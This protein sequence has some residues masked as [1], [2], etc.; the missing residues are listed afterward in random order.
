MKI[1]VLI[2]ILIVFYQFSKAQTNSSITGAMPGAVDT[3]SVL[4]SQEVSDDNK[5]LVDK[6]VDPEKYIVGPGDEFKVTIMQYEPKEI[7]VTVTLEN[8]TPGWQT[9]LPATVVL[10]RARAN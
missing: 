2:L 10:R 8:P 4:R 1:K 5:G 7:T 3:L 6:P 9:A